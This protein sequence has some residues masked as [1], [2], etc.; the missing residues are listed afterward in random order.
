M[1]HVETVTKKIRRSAEYVQSL[2]SRSIRVTLT[3][4]TYSSASTNNVLRNGN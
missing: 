4:S 3:G 1:G 2:M